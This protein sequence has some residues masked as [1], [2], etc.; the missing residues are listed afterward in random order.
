MFSRFFID[1]PRFTI[2]TILIMI[3]TGVICINKLPVSLYPDIA[4]PQVVIS[5][6]YPGASAETI[7][8]TVAIPIETQ[9]NG[10]DDILYF[11]SQSDNTGEYSCSVVFNTGTDPDMNMVNVQ[12]AVKLAESKLPDE[13]SR[14]GLTVYKR[15]SD[16]LALLAFRTDNKGMSLIQ[17]NNYV[18]TNINDPLQR[19]DG[20]GSALILSGREYSMRIWLDPLRMA[21]MGITTDDI[22]AAVRNQ[23]IQAAAGNIGSEGSNQYMEYKINIKGRLKTTDE[24]GNII[25]RNDSSDGSIVRLSDVADIELGAKQY[26]GNAYYNDEECVMMVIYRDSDANALA[27]MAGVKEKLEELSKRFPEGVSYAIGYD[28]TEFIDVSLQEIILTLIIA[29]ILVI[30]ITYL[31]LQDWRATMIPTIAIPVSLLATFPVM[32]LIGFSIN[33]LTM[34]GLI[35]VIG[36]LVDDAIVVVENTQA[37]MERE[38]LNAKEAAIKSMK[39]I[40]S[41]VIATTLVTLACYVPLAF[42]GGMVGEIY[43]Q[44]SVTMCTALCFSTFIALTLSPMLCAYLL[45]KPK[46][47][48]F[49]FF[50]AIDAILAR[51]RSLYL[52]G[53][54]M[55]IRRS[56]LSVLIFAGVLVGIYLLY[57]H[58]P[59]SFIPGEDQGEIMVNIELPSGAS[60]G[61]TNKVISKLE[62]TANSIEGVDFCFSVTGFSM[63]SGRGENVGAAFISLKKWDERNTPELQ[64]SAIIERLQQEFSKISAARI[65]CFT[66][67]AI[68]G[69]G[70]TGGSSFMLSASGD[71][72][73]QELSKTA[74]KYTMDL[75]KIPESLYAMTS[76]NA[77]SPELELIIN[78]QKAEMLGIPVQ[79]IFSSLQSKLA[80]L[81]IN[82]FNFAGESYY[83]KMQSSTQYRSSL[84]D[85]RDIQVRNNNNDMVPLTTFA[86]IKFTT[87]PKQIQRFN[88]LTSAEFNAQ[89]MPGVSSGTLMEKIAKQPLPPKYHIEWTGMSYQEKKNEGQI[90]VLML[91]ALLFAYFFLVAQYESWTTPIPVMLAVSFAVFGALVG[92]QT[93]SFANSLGLYNNIIDMSIYAQLGLVMLI[94]LSAKN[95]ILMIEF[96]KNEREIGASIA[97]SAI[98]GAKLRFRAV[99]MTAFSFIFGVLPLVV[100]SGAGAA[101][102]RAIGVTTFSGMLM[103]TLVGLFFT[104]TLFAIFQESREFFSKRRRHRRGH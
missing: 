56:L 72:T 41:A 45:K 95:A 27:T 83:V 75:N 96:S 91:L 21:G 70:V 84:D 42:Y 78:R 36:S 92:L 25:L 60:L 1:R 46:E 52:K 5:A 2:V 76:Y 20:V 31:F 40:T 61:R 23:N 38:G 73:P 50:R 19:V 94:G 58:I 64:I 55:L 98:N 69:L 85:I 47:K 65:I 86:N 87:G 59:S 26:S 62:K 66:P 18:S 8:N 6:F 13:V 32:L 48:K 30:A 3:L 35:L 49:V 14:I 57:N 7:A 53:V 102:R 16:I 34:F 101:S 104:P 68:M 103:A 79:R 54:I 71:V 81:Y 93:T 29:I 4:P 24:F 39:Q 89:A 82:D 88:K 63:M 80:S 99:L 37:I 15:T 77:D 33:T 90:V 10:V 67:P 100:A 44:F 12:N 74:K 22:T 43:T 11:S 28:P 9:V 97:K 51:T 17:L